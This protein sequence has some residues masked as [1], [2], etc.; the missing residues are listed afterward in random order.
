MI[1]ARNVRGGLVLL[2]GGLAGG[3]VMSLYAFA[4]LVPVPP[5]LARYDDLPRRLLRLAHIAG[6][7]LP[8][9][10]VI[11]GPWLDRLRLPD[12]V[13]RAASRLLLA[14]AATLPGA[15]TLEAALPPLIPLHLS[16]P[17]AL[18]F[19]AGIFIVGAGAYR[20]D[21]TSGFANEEVP[22]GHPA[23]ADRADSRHGRRDE[24]ARDPRPLLRE[25]RG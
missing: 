25:T 16:A 15:L 1:G 21:F 19:C 13:K 17:P 4:P 10:N 6:I 11:V 9:I 22:H 12:A 18:A 3:L 23:H 14:G 8:L 20:T 2:G 5:A 7:M 24:D